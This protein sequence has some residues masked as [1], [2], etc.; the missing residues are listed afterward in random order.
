M[1]SPSGGD[2]CRG[3]GSRASERWTDVRLVGPLPHAREDNDQHGHS[4]RSIVPSPGSRFHGNFGDSG[5]CRLERSQRVRGRPNPSSVRG[6]TA[7]GGT[8]ADRETHHNRTSL[9]GQAGDF[10]SAGIL[11]ESKKS[12]FCA[13]WFRSHEEIGIRWN[14]GWLKE[15]R[16]KRAIL[17]IGR[18]SATMRE[19][20]TH[21]WRSISFSGFQRNRDV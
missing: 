6:S 14:F 7:V 13:R 2:G 19:Y 20:L 3:P 21:S 16:R 15:F 9:P 1:V 12:M 4:C 18:E 5:R 10:P 17:W 8:T 11:L